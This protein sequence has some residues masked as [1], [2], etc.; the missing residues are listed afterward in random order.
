MSRIVVY[1]AGGRAGVR[2]V[3][4]AARRGHE[5]TAVVRDPDRYAHLSEVPV[6]GAEGPRVEGRGAEARGAEARGAEARGAE[7]PGAVGL[8]GG[9]VGDRRGRVRVV[10][11]DVTDAASVAETAAGHGAAIQ[12]AARLDM[13]SEEFYGAAARALAEGLGRAG[14]S[15]LVALGI[16]SLL[17]VSPGVRLIDTPGFPAE[18]RAFSLGHAVELAVL[19]E[20]G[21]DWVV[22]APPP[23]ILDA[24]ATGTGR[25][26]F[27]DG[28]VPEQDPADPVFS[29]ADLAAALVDEVERPRRHRAQVAVSY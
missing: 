7:G 29:Y 5:V 14:V 9:G 3:A 27:G 1:G 10:G 23:V 26:R 11:G 16:G 15:R 25:Y 17:E 4:E 13:P 18:A 20:S 19:A 22:L 12:V 21:L 28:R 2:V 6:L 8:R 24:E